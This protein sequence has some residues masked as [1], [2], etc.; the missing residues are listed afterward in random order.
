[1]LNSLRWSKKA[2]QEEEVKLDFRPTTNKN[3]NSRT[4][5]DTSTFEQ[6][7]QAEISRW[8]HGGGGAVISQVEWVPD[9]QTG[10][11][12]ALFRPASTRILEGAAAQQQQQKDVSKPMVVQE[13]VVKEPVVPVSA[14]LP[15]TS[16]PP[17]AKSKK[18]GRPN[19]EE[20]LKRTQEENAQY[21]KKVI[22]EAIEAERKALE[23]RLNAKRKPQQG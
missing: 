1:M 19:K 10:G 14:P 5:R 16:K 22:E 11:Q 21:A 20:E 13:P 12:I 3:N 23:S 2:P 4:L 8:D 17:G 7:A 9:P 15:P 6:L 18:S